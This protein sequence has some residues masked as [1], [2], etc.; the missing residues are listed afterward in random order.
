MCAGIVA[1]NPKDVDIDMLIESL[2]SCARW[3]VV[4]DNSST[5]TSYLKELEDEAGS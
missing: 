1:H 4:V 2:L 3:V 5:N